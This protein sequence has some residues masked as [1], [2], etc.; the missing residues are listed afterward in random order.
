MVQGRT[1]GTIMKSG[2]RPQRGEPATDAAAGQGKSHEVGT[3]CS[4]TLCI[5]KSGFA[6]GS[7]RKLSV[8]AFTGEYSSSMYNQGARD[9]RKL[10]LNGKIYMGTPST[11]KS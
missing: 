6:L 9:P 1:T 10:D 5:R 11:N 3:V 8:Y 2:S 7:W 4:G